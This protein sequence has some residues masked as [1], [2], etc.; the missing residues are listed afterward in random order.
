MV[1]VVGS[2]NEWY[3]AGVLQT[4]TQKNPSY[5]LIRYLKGS[6]VIPCFFRK[7]MRHIL[8]L[9]TSFYLKTTPT[10]QCIHCIVHSYYHSQ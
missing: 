2:N 1:S 6:W 8:R 7:Y 4:N 9:P 5:V 10:V 3:Y